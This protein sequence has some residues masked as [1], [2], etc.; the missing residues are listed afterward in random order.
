[1]KNIKVNFQ[2]INLIKQPI[3][4]DDGKY[5]SHNT[6]TVNCDISEYDYNSNIY[7]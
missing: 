1:M 4:V 6:I 2:I 5:T 7:W 3:M